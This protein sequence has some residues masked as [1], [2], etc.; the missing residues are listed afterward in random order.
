MKNKKATRKND[1]CLSTVLLTDCC[2]L[3][4]LS[5]HPDDIAYSLGGTVQQFHLDMEWTI[6]T[7]FGRSVYAPH[8]P[9]AVTESD[10]SNIRNRED[11]YYTNQVG[12]RLIKFNFP[13]AS[14]MG[15]TSESE[16]SASYQDAR[17]SKICSSLDQCLRNIRPDRIIIPLALCDHVD[18]R[19]V[20]EAASRSSALLC[21][22]VWY[23]EDLPYAWYL[24]EEDLQRQIRARLGSAANSL[25]INIT[26]ELPRKLKMLAGYSSQICSQDQEVVINYASRVQSGAF[27]YAERLW[28]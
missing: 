12:A 16:L 19:I 18:H 9:K 21:A 22:D 2:K 4:I 25:C 13:D 14:I 15:Y 10:I 7:V 17:F 6:L 3:V 20:F 24:S 1:D 28:H 23:Y 26:R 8:C 5:P 27:M 11:V